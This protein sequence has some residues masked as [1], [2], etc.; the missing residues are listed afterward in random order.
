MIISPIV[1]EPLDI[2]DMKDL[3]TAIKKV[4]DNS[5]LIYNEFKDKLDDEI[6]TPVSVASSKMFDSR[7]LIGSGL[8]FLVI[9][10]EQSL[11]SR[12]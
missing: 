12:L 6:V 3:V 2:S 10:V 11:Y 5:E 9:L 8:F 1:R 7:R 4:L